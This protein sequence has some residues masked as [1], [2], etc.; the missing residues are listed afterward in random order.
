VVVLGGSEA[1]ARKY[2]KAGGAPAVVDTGTLAGR[3]GVS[4]IP[5]TVF[6][7]GEGRIA[8]VKV[9]YSSAADLAAYVDGIG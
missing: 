9:G 1:G 7:D 4:A 6:I 5:T 2:F 8:N 3:F